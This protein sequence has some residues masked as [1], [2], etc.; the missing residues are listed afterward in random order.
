MPASRW[1]LAAVLA[2]GIAGTALLCASPR[3][4]AEDDPEAAAKIAKEEMDKAIARGKELWNSKE[5]GRKTCK[6][7]HED[8]DKPEDDL[9]Q[10]EWTY[11]AYSRRARRVVTLQ[12][13]INEMIKY[14][15]RG[16]ELDAA[17][18]DIAALAAYAESLRTK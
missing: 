3:V 16:K 14:K 6:Q 1:T 10:V 13:K 4:G 9:T 7:C 12:Q 11:P 17:G 15:A 2:A 8:P 5:L 18:A